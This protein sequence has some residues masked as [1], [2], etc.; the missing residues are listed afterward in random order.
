MGGRELATGDGG[1]SRNMLTAGS[2]VSRP[3]NSA[4]EGANVDRRGVGIRLF[5][6]EGAFRSSLDIA[7]CASGEDRRASSGNVVVLLMGD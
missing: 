3:P 7:L 5:G 1:I 6:V 2:W 4:S